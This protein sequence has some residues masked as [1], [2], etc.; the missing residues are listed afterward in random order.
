MDKQSLIQDIKSELLSTHIE[1][2]GN[3]KFISLLERKSNNIYNNLL[4]MNLTH[5]DIQQMLLIN[6]KEDPDLKQYL[7]DV[8]IC[9]LPSWITDKFRSHQVPGDGDCLFHSLGAALGKSASIVRREICNYMYTNQT[10]FFN[11]ISVKLA[12]SDMERGVPR[13]PVDYI[14]YMRTEKI[15]WGTQIE[16]Y[17][18]MLLYR[19]P[20]HVYHPN[21]QIHHNQP[22]AFIETFI[23]DNNIRSLPADEINIFNCSN[24]SAHTIYVG[25]YELLIPL[26]R[27][28]APERRVA[29]AEGSASAA[30]GIPYID[31]A[32]RRRRQAGIERAILGVSLVRGTSQA[33][34]KQAARPAAIS[35]Q[36]SIPD[37]APIL[38]FVP[39]SD[40]TSNA[41]YGHTSAFS[42][43]P[44]PAASFKPTP[45]P[46]PVASPAA[47][48]KPIPA[49][50]SSANIS[51]V[52]R[53]ATLER[54]L[55]HKADKKELDKPT[56]IKKIDISEI[57]TYLELI[58]SI[59]VLTHA[60]S[61]QI[62]QTIQHILTNNIPIT[63]DSF[64]TEIS[65]I[66]QLPSVEQ[67]QNIINIDKFIKDNNDFIT[68][69]IYKQIQQI[70]VRILN[71]CESMT[72]RSFINELR[73]K[74]IMDFPDP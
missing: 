25:H 56:E 47:S 11:N 5:Q 73:K 41:L 34:P 63:V 23:R 59:Y 68:D 13:K 24:D 30:T 2:T 21:T 17:A 67:L 70:R 64:I 32:E 35:A 37:Y 58:K 27:A 10:T 14:K 7:S 31:E 15:A 42:S 3:E 29:A 57:R 12:M 62:E 50:A 9:Y 45:P 53:I 33:G 55:E 1:L 54:R 6:L 72:L 74:R 39:D 43:R 8:Y 65:Y 49:A 28:A 16:V 61:I 69:D 19:R 46:R 26:G 40:P 51:V 44:I 22:M 48:Y 4:K 36:S 66:T 71:S 52:D 20:I 18:A 60:K 38:N